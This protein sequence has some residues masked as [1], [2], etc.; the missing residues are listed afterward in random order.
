MQYKSPLYDE[1]YNVLKSSELFGNLQD[2]I[3][4][5]IL[6]ECEEVLWRKGEIIDSSVGMKYMHIVIKGRVKITQIDP[7]SGRSLA[8]FILQAGDIFDLFSLLDGEEHVVFPVPLDNVSLLRIPLDRAREWIANHP[9][10]NKAF[11]PY[12]GKQMRALEEFGQSV[13]FCD[14]AT[15]LANLILKH[16]DNDKNAQTHY[17]VKLINNLSH[18][19][20][21]EMIGS[22]RSVVSTQIQKLKDEGVLISKRGHMAVENLEKLMKKC[23]IWQ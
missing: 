18:E 9:E 23:T 12:L 2:D 1:A 6:S 20:L 15:R 19:S 10:F 11:L 22:V 21:A 13:V 14:T 7:E 8:L 16:T 4:Q 17:P 3:L 5:D